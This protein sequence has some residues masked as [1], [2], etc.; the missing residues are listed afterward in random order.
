MNKD[1][2][3]YSV[4]IPVYKSEKTLS[5][6]YDRL[7]N[8][9]ENQVKGTFEVI[10]VDDASPDN[11]WHKMKELHDKDQ[12]FKIIRLARNFGQHCALMCGFNYVS[13][14]YIITMDDDLQHPPEEIPKLIVALENSPDIDVIIGNYNKKKHSW[15]R[16]IGTHLNR[17]IMVKIFGLNKTYRGGSFRLIK[18]NTVKAIITQTTY[19]PRIGQLLKLV[20]NKYGFVTVDHQPRQH[21]KSGYSISRLSRDFINNILNNSTIILRI[22]SVLGFSSAGLSMI[23]ATYYLVKYFTVGIAV[24]GFTTII[25]IN[26]FFSGI[27]L[28]SLGVVG[29][30]LMKILFEARKY[31]QYVI[32][33]KIF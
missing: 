7:V 20:T 32:H 31:P 5:E 12:R 1:N 25:L 17:L 15:W 2:P 33:Q 27:I 8:V 22:S 29:E 10:L 13:G 16:N 4:V 28:F 6:L 11:S 3:V 24:P 21:G 23:L 30:Y 18:I 14:E 19:Q 26:L 9:F